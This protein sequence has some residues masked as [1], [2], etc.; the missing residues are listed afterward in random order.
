[1]A[2]V[3]GTATIGAPRWINITNMC[4]RWC[5]SSSAEGL[6]F[7]PIAAAF[8]RGRYCSGQ[9][10]SGLAFEGLGT[11]RRAGSSTEGS[12]GAG[13]PVVEVASAG[14]FNVRFI[15]KANF[16]LEARLLSLKICEVSVFT[17]RKSGQHDRW[18]QRIFPAQWGAQ[19][20]ATRRSSDCTQY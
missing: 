18:G 12:G 14:P 6:R 4:R 13:R 7:P 1:M 9:A 2:G 19:S 11:N 17:G 3:R 15:R 10:A 5:Y 20:T 8:V 16:E